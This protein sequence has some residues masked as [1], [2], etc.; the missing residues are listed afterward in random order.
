ME[1]WC[2][3]FFKGSHLDGVHV[4]NFVAGSGAIFLDGDEGNDST[5]EDGR[6]A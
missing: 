6:A 1:I 5:E 4:N 2:S 3:C